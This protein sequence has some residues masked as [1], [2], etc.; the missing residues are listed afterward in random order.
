MAAVALLVAVSGFF[1]YQ[2]WQNHNQEIIY[3]TSFKE[4]G[5]PEDLRD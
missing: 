2:V 5:M 4:W 3:R 1:G